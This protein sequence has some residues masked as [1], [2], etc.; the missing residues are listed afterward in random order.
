MGRAHLWRLAATPPF[1][2]YLCGHALA[3]T[4]EWMKRAIVGWLLWE[5]TG[6]ATWL[7][8]FAFALLAPSALGT[9]WGGALADRQ[10]RRMLIAGARAVAAGFCLCVAGLV[11]AGLAT[12]GLIVGLASVAGLAGGLAQASSKTIVSDLVP[13]DRLANA[14][15]LNATAFNVA[16]MAGPAL[17]ALLL[18]GPG[19]GVALVLAGSGLA[20]HAM[21]VLTL[22]P[23]PRPARPASPM[24]RD[25][26]EGFRTVAVSPVL[27]PLMLLHFAGALLVRP[28]LD[29]AP[30]IAALVLGRGPDGMAILT[31]GVGAGA[32]LGGLWL[33]GADRTR[34][35]PTLV[36]VAAVV[37]ATTTA[38]LP[39][40]TGTTAML[41]LAGA[42]GAASLVRAAG[43]QSLLQLSATPELRG[44]VLG[45]YG[46]ILHLGAAI[47]GLSLGLIADAVGL[48]V[49][50]WSAALLLA[51]ASVLL[52]PAL[53]AARTD[54]ERQGKKDV[55]H[56]ADQ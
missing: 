26:A 51:T 13:R 14:V 10:D 54:A 47:G 55:V 20:A 42:F 11:G 21:I 18:V 36:L 27:R 12:P 16:T 3:A 53:L 45:V 30:A 4:G 24:L 56:D 17:A 15:A 8:A 38:V 50:L 9:I 48:G 43:I 19:A 35:L 23:A 49:A 40:L 46:L 1:G 5:M 22:P 2:P 6:S 52:A 31:G 25:I 37:L 32:I 34:R 33:A 44:R 29:M 39:L 41:L 28:V 7:G